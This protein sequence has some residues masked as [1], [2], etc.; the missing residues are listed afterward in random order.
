MYTL[1]CIV[2]EVDDGQEHY[3]CFRHYKSTLSESRRRNPHPRLEL[4]KLQIKTDLPLHASHGSTAGIVALD[5]G[6]AVTGA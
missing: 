1:S 3:R 4:E 5:L 6:E 2:H